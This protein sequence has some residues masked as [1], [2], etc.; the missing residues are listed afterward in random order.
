MKKIWILSVVFAIFLTGCRGSFMQNEEKPSAGKPGAEDFSEVQGYYFRTNK[1]KDVLIDS[2]GTL[3]ILSNQSGA[4][5]LFDGVTNGDRIVVTLDGIAETYPEEAGCYSCVKQQDG[6]LNDIPDDAIQKLKELGWFSEDQPVEITVEELTQQQA[7]EYEAQGIT[8]LGSGD[9]VYSS[10][11]LVSFDR[12]VTELSLWRIEMDVILNDSYIG[13]ETECIGSVQS[14]IPDNQVILAGELGELLPTLGIS[15]V[16][17]KGTK[18]HDY[19]AVSGKDGSPMLIPYEIFN[20][21]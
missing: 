3:V 1:G 2:A 11:F 6:E 15:F 12:A 20:M 18:I 8:L 16:T 13:S 19:F 14:L 9:S 5:A 10:Y 7:A 21:E 4:E 17:D